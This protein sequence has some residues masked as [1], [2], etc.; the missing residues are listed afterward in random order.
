MPTQ[1]SQTITLFAEGVRNDGKE[2]ILFDTKL[3]DKIYFFRNYDP[4][5]LT[6]IASEVLKVDSTI[7]NIDN[8][9]DGDAN[10]FG[11][12]E[13]T[14][15]GAHATIKFDF[16]SVA[17]REVSIIIDEGHHVIESSYS[18][19]GTTFSTPV[20]ETFHGVGGKKIITLK[21]GRQ[22]LQY[23]DLTIKSNLDNS[24]ITKIYQVFDN[25]AEGGSTSAEIQIENRTTGIWHKVGTLPIINGINGVNETSDIIVGILPDTNLTRVV[26]INSGDWFGSVSALLVNPK[27]P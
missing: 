22:N 13:T 4:R 24:E 14:K 25:L 17:S 9:A 16:K 23:V 11:T 5:Y 7:S 10:T 15:T 12:V 27:F 8:M 6:K 2:E 19:D 1:H 18:T 3:A 20:V 26:L 21:F